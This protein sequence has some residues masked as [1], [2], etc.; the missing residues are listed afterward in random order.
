MREWPFV[1]RDAELARLS[2]LIADPEARGVVLAGPAGVGKTRVGLELLKRATAAGMV[3]ERVMATKIKTELAFAAVTMLLP[4]GSHHR[5]VG[6]LAELAHALASE[7][8]RRAG[9]GRLA[10]LVDDAHLLDDGSAMLIHQLVMR[11]SVFVIATVATGEPAPGPVVALW[12][13]D[14]VERVDLEPLGDESIEQTVSDFL[15]GPVAGAVVVSLARR[16]RGNMLFVRELVHGALA[17]EA[18][19]CEGGIWHLVSELYPSKR[20]VELLESRLADTDPDEREIL[21]L[22]AVGE[23][24]SDS[25]LGTLASEALLDQLEKKG[26]ISASLVH[27]RFSV[28][29]AHPLYGE[30]L[31]SG[32]SAGRMRRLTRGLA[33]ALEAAG[34]HRPD[35]LLRIGTWRLKCGGGKP[36]LL[37]AAAT[38][39]FDRFDYALAE[40]LAQAAIEAGAGFDAQLLL[41]ELTAR[42]GDRAG[43]EA[44]LLRLWIMAGDDAHRTR[45]AL[46]RVDNALYRIRH[47]DAIRICAEALSVVEDP[48][49]RS[50]IEVR[51]SWAVAYA[52]GPQAAVESVEAIAGEPDDATR[53]VNS[54]E[55]FFLAHLGRSSDALRA[56]SAG[57]EARRRVTGELHWP[58]AFHGFFRCEALAVAGRFV[59]MEETAA[60]IYQSALNESSLVGEATGAHQ[61]A[62]ALAERGRVRSAVRYAREASTLFG[63]LGD[64]LPLSQS[65]LLVAYVCALTG[66]ASAAADA[67]AQFDRLQLPTVWHS[68]GTQYAR[69]WVAAASNNLPLARHLFEEEVTTAERYGDLARAG[70]A[71]HALVRIGYPAPAA[72]PLRSLAARVEG[73]LAAL[74]AAHACALLDK[75]AGRLDEAS[76][77]FEAIGADLLAAEVAADTAVIWRQARESRQAKAAEHRAAKLLDQCE[78]ATT[79]AT[80]SVEARARLTPTER[81][82]AVLAGEGWS[83]KEIATQLNVA[84]RTVES[85]LQTIYAKLGVSSRI[86]LGAQLTRS[87]SERPEKRPSPRKSK[88]PRSEFESQ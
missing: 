8:I 50:A 14:L 79:P 13:E 55:A 53:I 72:E 5:P 82:T 27:G 29:L 41:G 75:D 49:S 24:L 26:L 7:V 9:A 2:K 69:G 51:R 20:L 54:A 77:R 10:L 33:E 63:S 15:G 56:V 86:D 18:L 88:P 64:T 73:D 65:Q 48:R 35:D 52:S 43:A 61:L 4:E 58:S 74:R 84:I 80:G 39:G 23:P 37:L 22:L 42:Q 76:R 87:E 71:L 60:D 44:Q 59:E 11:R 19:R 36:D 62:S 16:S 12:K 17:Q 25:E 32:I 40:E 34:S 68:L 45:V 28:V 21:E 6:E 78:G 47:D 3:P 70:A 83:N 30:V 38:I 81:E 31:R 1:G 67:M 85:R 57:E 66:D 46:A